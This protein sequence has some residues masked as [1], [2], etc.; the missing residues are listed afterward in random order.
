MSFTTHLISFILGGISSLAALVA[1][2]YL[3]ILKQISKSDKLSSA[4]LHE[5]S[6]NV[7]T[8]PF[9]DSVGYSEH[10]APKKTEPTQSESNTTSIDHHQPKSIPKEELKSSKDRERSK[11]IDPIQKVPLLNS[12]SLISFRQSK[13]NLLLAPPLLYLVLLL[14]PT[15]LLPLLKNQSV[16]VGSKCV[17][18]FTY[19]LL[20][21]SLTL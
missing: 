13:P 2:V 7:V 4:K 18:V 8:T 6:A 11:T 19:F 20:L 9:L 10:D 17:A 1:V 5:Q 12:I 3:V 14:L 16:S 15:L 21:S